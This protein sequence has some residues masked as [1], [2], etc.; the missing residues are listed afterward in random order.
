MEFERDYPETVRRSGLLVDGAS[1]APA[2]SYL[3]ATGLSDDDFGKPLIAVVN[4]WSTVTPCNMHLGVL[5]QA[6]RDGIT[7]AGG[8]P[9]DFNTIVVSDGVAMASG[10][11]A[12]A[13]QPS[14]PDETA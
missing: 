3:R 2:R 10:P 14:N 12:S 9:V 4:S 11:C 7:T 6:V 8:V 5:A 13:T 1:R